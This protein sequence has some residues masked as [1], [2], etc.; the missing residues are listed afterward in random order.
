MTTLED[1]SAHRYERIVAGVLLKIATLFITCNVSN[2]I[3]AKLTG[4]LVYRHA[5]R[6]QSQSS[7]T[8]TLGGVWHID[9]E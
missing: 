5:R 4:S 1:D 3:T 8:G 7:W 9:Y 2:L 6:T